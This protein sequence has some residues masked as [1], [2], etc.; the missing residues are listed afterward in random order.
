MRLH[1]FDRREFIRG[2]RDWFPDMDPRLLALLDVFRHLWGAPVAISPHPAALG[3][4]LPLEAL[5]DHN[6]TRHRAV[7]AADVMPKGMHSRAAAA[8]ALQLARDVTFT[9]IGLYPDWQPAAGLHL[10]IRRDRE[11]GAPALWGAVRQN[12][13]QVYV[14]LEQALARLGGGEPNVAS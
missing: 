11:P 9:A 13:R 6:F 3:R 2:D 5:S 12:D 10:A 8:R 4:L 7:L 1:Y 14:T